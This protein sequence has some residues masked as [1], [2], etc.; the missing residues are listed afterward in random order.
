MFALW[1]YNDNVLFVFALYFRR[2]APDGSLIIGF[3]KIGCDPVG[4]EDPR[5]T[6]IFYFLL[7]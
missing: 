1:F 4:P 2:E 3:R 5:C 7:K 6:D